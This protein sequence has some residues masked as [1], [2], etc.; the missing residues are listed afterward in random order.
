MVQNYQIESPNIPAIGQNGIVFYPQQSIPRYPY[1]YDPG[2][3]PF[4]SPEL[5]GIPSYP[6]GSE[7]LPNPLAEPDAIVPNQLFVPN[8]NLI[9]SYAVP[10]F[11]QPYPFINDD[12][13]PNFYPTLHGVNVNYPLINTNHEIPIIDVEEESKMGWRRP[14]HFIKEKIKSFFQRKKQKKKG[15]PIRW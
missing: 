3:F 1:I 10:D 4:T 7:N 9:Q 15:I 14:F 8:P 11:P 6:F 13:Q 12:I 2:S 5:N